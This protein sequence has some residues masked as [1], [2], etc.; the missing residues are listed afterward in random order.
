MSKEYGRETWE[1]WQEDKGEGHI[2]KKEN[3]FATVIIAC[4]PKRINWKKTIRDLI[5]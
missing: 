5:K 1:T 3:K 4:K 2:F